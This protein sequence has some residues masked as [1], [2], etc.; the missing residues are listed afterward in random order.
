MPKHCEVLII[1]GGIIGSFTAYWL[2]TIADRANIA[3]I[4]RDSDVTVFF[5]VVVDL[6][7]AIKFLL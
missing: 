4:E 7:L 5:F 1:G 2:K 6:G 3:V